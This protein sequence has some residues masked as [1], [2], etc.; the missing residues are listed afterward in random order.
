M[1]ASSRLADPRS[2]MSFWGR[3]ASTLPEFMREMRSQRTLRSRSGLSR[4]RYA[5]VPERSIREP[6]KLSRATGR[7]RTWVVQDQDL[8]S[9]STHRQREALPQTHRQAVGERI[10]GGPRPNRST[11]S[12]MRLALSGGMKN[13]RRGPGSRARSA[14]RRERRPASCI[15]VSCGPPCSR[16]RLTAEQRR[17]P[18][19]RQS[20]VSIFMVVISRSRWSRGNRR[21]RPFSIG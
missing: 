3:A 11:S 14:H 5:L 9:C 17:G 13:A 18:P 6:Q 15:R 2:S 7:P 8:R 21:S 19:G 20:P 16:P 10:D 12:S 4:R 1:K